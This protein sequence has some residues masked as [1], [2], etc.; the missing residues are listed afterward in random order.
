MPQPRKGTDAV[1]R[2]RGA[3]PD[4]NVDLVDL[5]L[6]DL[7]SVARAADAVAKEPR[8]DVLD[9]DASRNDDPHRRYFQSKLVNL[10]F[11]YERRATARGSSLVATAAHPGGA[12]MELNCYME[13][14]LA[15]AI[16]LVRP[17]YFGLS[18]WWESSGSAQQVDSTDASKDLDSAKRLWDISVEMTAFEPGL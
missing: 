16:R 10:L 7:A 18:R 4:A 14:G 8:L 15:L 2:I 9:L 11:T 3:H 1:S 13:G 12:D 5:D 17:L 6:G